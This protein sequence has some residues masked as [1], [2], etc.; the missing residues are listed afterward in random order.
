MIKPLT[1]SHAAFTLHP[2]LQYSQHDIIPGHCTS[3]LW[4][5]REAPIM[6]VRHVSAPHIALTEHELRE[7]ATTPPV[8]VLQI[9]CEILPGGWSM[10]AR[11]P[12]GV[13]LL[14]I[15]QAIHACLQIQLTHDEWDAMSLKQ[16]GRI[17]KVFDLRW[18][19]SAAPAS[20][21]A[22]GVIRADC[23]LQHT[24]FGGLTRSL[25]TADSCILTLRRPYP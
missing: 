4:D 2:L 12:Q 6:S 15:L 14:D 20:T 19:V 13:T 23:L 5:L 8:P 9:T 18:R 11:N 10:T 16:Q 22:N 25:V 17:S 21:H 1:P 3:L 24:L 7:H